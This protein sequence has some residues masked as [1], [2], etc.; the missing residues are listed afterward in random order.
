M[1]N[2]TGESI[3]FVSVDDLTRLRLD[4]KIIEER[5]YDTV[6]GPW[7]YFTADEGQFHLENRNY[8][9]IGTLESYGKLKEYFGSEKVVP[10]YVETEDGLRL[11]RAM[12]REEKQ[13][14]HAA[15]DCKCAGVFCPIVPIF[16]K[17]RSGKRGSENGLRITES[18][19]NAWRN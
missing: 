15:L 8:I 14:E 19:P 4:G 17:K 1:A 6:Y 12:Q 10:L 5:V 7:H 18:F 3:F 13:Q 16:L 9:G 2:R 11:R